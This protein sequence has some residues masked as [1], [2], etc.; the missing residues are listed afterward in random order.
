MKKQAGENY[1]FQTFFNVSLA[2]GNAEVC[3]IRFN[4]N[5][6]GSEAVFHG[7]GNSCGN[8]EKPGHPELFNAVPQDHFEKSA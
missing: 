2:K 7:Q 6:A 1:F 3:E 8:P 5:C 4:T